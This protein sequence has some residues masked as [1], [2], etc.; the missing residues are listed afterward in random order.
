[1]L[2]YCLF[3]TPIITVDC[4][5]LLDALLEYTTHVRVPP[6]ILERKTTMAVL[7]KK[8]ELPERMEGSRCCGLVLVSLG[9]FVSEM[10]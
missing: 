6:P 2:V 8:L 7:K 1:M 4:F 9:H 3:L 5:W 10:F